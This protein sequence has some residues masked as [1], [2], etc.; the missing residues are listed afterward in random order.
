MNCANVILFAAFHTFHVA[1]SVAVGATSLNVY[2]A[3]L[4]ATFH[5]P[6]LTYHVTV[7]LHFCPAVT[8]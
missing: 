3:V 7:T 2:V 1:K 4:L 6:S 8:V 5:C